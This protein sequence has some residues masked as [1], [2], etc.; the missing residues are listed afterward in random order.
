[1]HGICKTIW[2]RFI[3]SRFLIY[4]QYNTIR[5]YFWQ[6]S[7][8]DIYR[9]YTLAPFSRRISSVWIF[10]NCLVFGV[11]FTLQNPFYNIQH[12]DFNFYLPNDAALLE[13]SQPVVENHYVRIAMLPTRCHD[14]TAQDCIAIGWGK[15]QGITVSCVPLVYNHSYV[16]ASYSRFENTFY[17]SINLRGHK[18]Q[19]LIVC[20]HTLTSF[21]FQCLFLKASVP[22]PCIIL[23]YQRSRSRPMP[24]KSES[25]FIKKSR[26]SI[27]YGQFYVSYL[28]NQGI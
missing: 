4:L 22:W 8:A 26:F 18:T 1:M 12:P 24:N 10:I 23:I 16:L 13:L 7:V 21:N 3:W 11:F 14:F 27:P 17:S 25:F 20:P 2:S 19:N 28:I 9:A 6:W 5:I 15:T